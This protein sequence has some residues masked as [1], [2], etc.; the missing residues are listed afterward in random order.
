MTTALRVQMI[1]DGDARGAKA[2]ASEA[3]AAVKGLSGATKEAAGSAGTH[4]AATNAEAAAAGRLATAE[5][6]AA[7]QVVR[8]NS[9]MIGGMSNSRNFAMQMSQVAQQGAITGNYLGAL[10][11]QLPDL[12]LGFGDVAIAASIVA[13]IALPMV[14]G[15]FGDGKTAAEQLA[16]ATGEIGYSI[17]VLKGIVQ[18]FADG[19]LESL[20]EKY[21]EIDTQLLTL[22][23]HQRE[24]EIG[25]AQSAGR[26]AIAA[27][28][29]E[30]GAL[31]NTI[32][33]P[34]KAGLQA[35]TQLKDELGL[36]ARQ[37]R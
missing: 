22:I 25:Q 20:R 15:A 36:T 35:V 34:S 32:N 17:S 33:Q 28:A 26:D 5:A 13:T 1:L 27:I 31:L 21:G 16:D 10:A 9:A 37:G 8:V 3:A 11:I 23:K 7:A 12:A 18:D 24:Q 19:S 29:D 30:Y 2:A 4:T 14:I 6:A